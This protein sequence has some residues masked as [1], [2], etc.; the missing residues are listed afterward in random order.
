MDFNVVKP[1]HVMDSKL[2]MVYGAI[3]RVGNKRVKL[4]SSRNAITGNGASGDSIVRVGIVAS[5]CRWR[6]VA[7]GG[8]VYVKGADT[9]QEIMEWGYLISDIGAAD[10]DAFGKVTCVAT[11][12]KEWEAGDFM[13]QGI[14]PYTDFFGFD[15]LAS[16][17]AHVWD[18][19]GTGA[20]VSMG[21]WQTKAALLIATKKNVG[22]STALIMP[23]FLIEYETGGGVE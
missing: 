2:G 10:P 8:Y 15:A 12:N 21:E 16:A 14:A 13:Y 6:V 18:I 20:G 7:I 5:C 4:L 19:S 22:S 11:S 9:V 1:P 17:G 23:A 3:S